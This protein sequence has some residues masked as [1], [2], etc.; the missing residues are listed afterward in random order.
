MPTRPNQW[1]SEMLS[2]RLGASNECLL[3]H[4]I[5]RYVQLDSV[6]QDSLHSISEETPQ[7]ESRNRHNV[8]FRVL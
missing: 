7:C 4:E 8:D 1:C 2:G 5:K 3:S 6:A